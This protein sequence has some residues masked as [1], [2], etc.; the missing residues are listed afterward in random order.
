MNLQGPPSEGSVFA[1]FFKRVYTTNQ[2][3]NVT[4][5]PHNEKTPVVPPAPPQP[6][7]APPPLAS[8]SL[9]NNSEVESGSKEALEYLFDTICAKVDDDDKELIYFDTLT[10]VTLPQLRPLIE[11]ANLFQYDVNE[12]ISERR[13]NNDIKSLGS[14][15]AYYVLRVNNSLTQSLREVDHIIGQLQSDLEERKLTVKQAE[16]DLNELVAN[17][18]WDSLEEV[19][20]KLHNLQQTISTIEVKL[21]KS[22]LSECLCLLKIQRGETD[23]LN[24]LFL[25]QARSLAILITLLRHLSTI[26]NQFKAAEN[27]EHFKSRLNQEIETKMKQVDELTAAHERYEDLL[28]SNQIALEALEKEEDVSTA[29]KTTEIQNL[30]ADEEACSETIKELETQLRLKR[31]ELENIQAMKETARNDLESLKSRYTKESSEVKE[32][33]DDASSMLTAVASEL[34]RLR[35]SLADDQKVI[36]EIAGGGCGTEKLEEQLDQT[37]MTMLQEYSLTFAACK[38]QADDEQEALNLKKILDLMKS[39]LESHLNTMKSNVVTL[40]DLLSKNLEDKDEIKDLLALRQ[41]VHNLQATSELLNELVNITQQFGERKVAASGQEVE[42]AAKITHHQVKRSMLEKSIVQVLEEEKRLLIEKKLYRAAAI[43]K[44]EIENARKELETIINTIEGLEARQKVLLEMVTT[45]EK[46]HLA[47]QSCRSEYVTTWE[48][49]E[50][51]ARSLIAQRLETLKSPSLC[52]D[53]RFEDLAEPAMLKWLKVN[54]SRSLKKQPPSSNPSREIVAEESCI[55][56][57]QADDPTRATLKETEEV[58][59]VI[60][61]SEAEQVQGSTEGSSSQEV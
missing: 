11:R 3:N 40:L 35:E 23:F 9:S 32:R 12:W 24:E 57:G 4:E 25:Y 22:R 15:I 59:G 19:E 36:N 30:E 31:L 29:A 14:A 53:D 56:E 44:E 13:I 38:A 48:H 49:F 27:I 1:N 18:A 43:K 54:T 26:L 7:L 33:I 47:V 6:R 37:L 55:S 60:V 17:E 52:S 41:E 5:T 45:Y 20:T 21:D 50:S 58:K 46:C 34:S 8:H 16:E 10:T 61:D 2:S 42:L 39:S 51:Q 28:A